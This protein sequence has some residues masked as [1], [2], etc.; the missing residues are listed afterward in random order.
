MLKEL[1]SSPIKNAPKLKVN[2]TVREILISPSQNIPDEAEDLKMTPK[3]SKKKRK[4]EDE[5]P[6]PLQPELKEKRPN[7]PILF[8]LMSVSMNSCRFDSTL[9]TDLLEKF[10]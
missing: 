10:L 9:A 3:I 8:T 5:G 1:K 7:D 2:S 6:Y 4:N